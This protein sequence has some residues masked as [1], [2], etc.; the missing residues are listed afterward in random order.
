MHGIV[1]LLF[2]ST[3]AAIAAWHQ[4]AAQPSK[5]IPGTT[6]SSKSIICAPS[7]TA[8]S[9][10]LGVKGIL[11]FIYSSAH[12][13]SSIPGS[14]SS[15]TCVDTFQRRTADPVA[16][17]AANGQANSPPYDSYVNLPEDCKNGGGYSMLS[18][19]PQIAIAAIVVPI[20]FI[21]QAFALVLFA[22]AK[23]GY[24]GC[25][26]LGWGF[27]S[28]IAP[29]CAWI[30]I[31]MA[32]RKNPVQVVPAVVSHTTAAA[33]PPYGTHPQGSTFL[34]AYNGQPG[35]VPYGVQPPLYA[36]PPGFA[37]YPA[38]IQSQGYPMQPVGYGAPLGIAAPQQMQGDGHH[39]QP[40]SAPEGYYPVQGNLQQQ[41]AESLSK[42][43]PFNPYATPQ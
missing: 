41:Q 37:S 33:H 29:G 36:P 22:K 26:L 1:L 11:C 16:L 7:S 43:P 28:C 5:C 9:E 35:F 20:A 8:C 4:V 2:A 30:L 17:C 40:M 24:R 32:E 3:A 42:P 10:C 34:P 6:S 21:L 31:C 25:S 19:S 13:D 12:S 39:M 27:L 23:R 18:A 38:P 14:Y 15:T